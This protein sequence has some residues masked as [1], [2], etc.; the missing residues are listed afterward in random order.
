MLGDGTG[1]SLEYSPTLVTEAG[2]SSGTPAYEAYV[3]KSLSEL[4]E[5]HSIAS[6]VN[7]AHEINRPDDQR[8]KYMEQRQMDMEETTNTMKVTMS[9]F[10]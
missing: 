6:M 1:R 7:E 10:A 2:R 5:N 3:L 4:Q 9:D 8:Q